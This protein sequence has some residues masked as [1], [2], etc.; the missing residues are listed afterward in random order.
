[1]F[2]FLPVVLSLFDVCS[3]C[4]DLVISLFLSLVRY[5]SRSFFMASFLYLCM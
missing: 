5:F 1:M 4:S 2:V 3:F